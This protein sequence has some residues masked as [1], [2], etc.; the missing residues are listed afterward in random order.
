MYETR[1]ISRTDES[2][3]LCIYAS[4]QHQKL[5]FYIIIFLCQNFW[6]KYW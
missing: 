5:Q 3:I 4:M 6:V 2:I 1:I